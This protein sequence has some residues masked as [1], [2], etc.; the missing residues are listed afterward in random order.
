MYCYGEV[1]RAI[2]RLAALFSPDLF[3]DEVVRG[4]LTDQDTEFVKIHFKRADP[5]NINEQP[6]TADLEHF[7]RNLKNVGL[8]DRFTL[9]ARLFARATSLPP[10]F[11][12]ERFLWLWIVLEVY[13]MHDSSDIAAISECVAAITGRPATEVKDKLQIGRL[14]GARSKLVHDGRLPYGEYD[15]GD[16]LA[17]L[18]TIVVTILRAEGG[19]TY[20][21]RLDKAL[22]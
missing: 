20:D 15:L 8:D 5:V 10:S 1:D 11:A 14:F 2:T 9:Q 7:A 6:A 16:V 12:E 21:G 17:R 18:E 4:W 19:L 3:V 13:P 22:A